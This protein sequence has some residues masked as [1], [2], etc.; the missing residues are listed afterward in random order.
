MALAIDKSMDIADFWECWEH[1]LALVELEYEAVR[2]GKGYYDLHLEL[3]WDCEGVEQEII[4]AG[5]SG[6]QLRSW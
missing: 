3:N 5:N 1:I 4:V 6:G 2:D